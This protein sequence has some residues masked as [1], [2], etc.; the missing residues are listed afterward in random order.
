[1]TESE[2]ALEESHS[3]E[4]DFGMIRTSPNPELWAEELEKVPGAEQLRFWL[5][6]SCQGCKTTDLECDHG[7]F[8]Q[9]VQNATDEDVKDLLEELS[10]YPLPASTFLK[11]HAVVGAFNHLVVAR[12]QL[13]SLR[14]GSEQLKPNPLTEFLKGLH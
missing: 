9:L 4:P 8:I 6:Q 13:R 14:P 2:T 1:M 10:L 7:R 3:T 12:N 5:R 11:F